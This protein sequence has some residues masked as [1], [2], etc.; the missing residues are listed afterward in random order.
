MKVITSIHSCTGNV[1]LCVMN[2]HKSVCLQ[3]QALATVSV[4]RLIR[5]THA[6]GRAG[7]GQCVMQLASTALVWSIGP[8]LSSGTLKHQSQPPVVT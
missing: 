8:V 4:H 5:D 7:Q 2:V 6:H 3:Q 1:H